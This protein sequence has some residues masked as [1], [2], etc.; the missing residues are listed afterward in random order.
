MMFVK[1]IFSLEKKK[2]TEIIKLKR[3]NNAVYEKSYVRGTLSNFDRMYL[4]DNNSLILNI[5][6]NRY[7][8]KKHVK[9]K[10]HKQVA[11]EVKTYDSKLNKKIGSKDKGSSVYTTTFLY[12]N[13]KNNFLRFNLP[14]CTLSISKHVNI[15]SSYIEGI[16]K[17][18]ETKKV[19]ETTL[20]FLFASKG[21]FMCLSSSFLGFMPKAEFRIVVLRWAKNFVN[22]LHRSNVSGLTN[23][24]KLQKCQSSISPP[25]RFC[26][27]LERMSITIVLKRN[28]FLLSR[29]KRSYVVKN[30]N[31][32][33][34]FYS[35]NS[36]QTPLSLGCTEDSES[37]FTKT[38]PLLY[39][40][41]TILEDLTVDE[42]RK[43]K[44]KKKSK[45]FIP[46]V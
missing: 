39:G 36:Y 16:E 12:K 46:E 34:I 15:I 42:K 33:F 26:F 37:C 38:L 10:V 29:K 9:Q 14:S 23:F 4:L 18:F 31:P 25:P 1:E 30:S 27:L 45:K 32:F 19:E 3:F 11:F 5:K 17:I 43:I 8:K 2:L 6:K 44:H 22:F 28:R 41:H 21:G 40:K 7:L 13:R 24:L 35:M 20:I